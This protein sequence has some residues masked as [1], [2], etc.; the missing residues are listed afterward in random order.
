MLA[1]VMLVLV[2]L[3]LGRAT[4]RARRHDLGGARWIW[5]PGVSLAKSPPPVAFYASARLW[6]PAPPRQARLAIVAD[7]E[8]AAWLGDGWIG[9]GA[10]RPHGGVDVYEVADRLVAGE[11]RI[12]VELR[13]SRGAGGLLAVLEAD[14]RPLVASG[15][16]W[17]IHRR[18]S[19]DLWR[20]ASPRPT[21]EAPRLWGR[22]PT[23]RWRPGAASPP[24]G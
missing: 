7:E 1:L 18:W 19:A 17:R 6:L 5:A 15:A 23:G 13:S 12:V 24:R 14:G 8:Y 21:G 9:A 3:E 20:P 10:Y 11:N 22:P 4:L 16:E 2:G